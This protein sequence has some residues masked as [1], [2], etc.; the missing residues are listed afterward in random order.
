MM[1]QA[2]HGFGTNHIPVF[3]HPVQMIDRDDNKRIISVR[4]E[5]PIDS[6]I[7]FN[8]VMPLL[9]KAGVDLI[10]SGH[11]HL[12]FRINIDGITYIETSHV[13][14]SYG[15]YIDGYK[16][17]K[18]SPDDNRFEARNYPKTGDPHGLSP[19]MPTVFS[20]MTDKDGRG[21]PC[22]GSNDLT[23]FTILD[24]E[25]GALS[26]YVYDTREPESPPRLFDEVMIGRKQ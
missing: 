18:N 2:P 9:R 21:L 17:R 12:W 7:L 14:N 23:V 4:Y 25:R 20:P 19:A 15:C 5:Y 26:S 11:S 6:D 16:E 10:H 1:H 3:A 22:V 24:T 13:G 8:D